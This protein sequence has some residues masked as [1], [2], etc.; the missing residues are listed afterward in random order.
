MKNI[1][2]PYQPK[3]IKTLDIRD[4]NH[5]ARGEINKAIGSFNFT[6]S[7]QEDVE[8][9][10]KFKQIPGLVSFI[11]TLRKDDEIIGEGRGTATF[12]K[13]NKYVD[14]TVNTA[15][16]ASFV[17]SV[18]RSTRMLESFQTDEDEDE[19]QDDDIEKAYKEK[20]RYEQTQNITDK[21]KKFLTELVQTKVNDEEE[22]NGWLSQMNELT[23]EEASQA[24]ETF[25]A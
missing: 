14:R 15:L 25:L 3:S 16:K 23:K 19:W 17:D 18:V 12:S 5:P 2:S 11:C 13:I 7:F 9:L 21:Q 20:E 4:S 6:A 10:R 24:I 8:T 22:R 1:K